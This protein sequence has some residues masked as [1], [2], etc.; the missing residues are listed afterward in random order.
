MKLQIEKE[1]NH[2]EKLSGV[3]IEKWQI[4]SKQ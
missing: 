3:A 1:T 2:Q 4:I